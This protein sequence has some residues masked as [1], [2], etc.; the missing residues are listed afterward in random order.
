MLALKLTRPTGS[1]AVARVREC[2]TEM[3][4]DGQNFGFHPNGIRSTGSY[5]MAAIQVFFIFCY[6]RDG[7]KRKERKTC[8]VRKEKE[9]KGPS[10]ST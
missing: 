5:S 4:G 8:N 6:L 9:R 7:K 3:V 2:W 1:F 10:D